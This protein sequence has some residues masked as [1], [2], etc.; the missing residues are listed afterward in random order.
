MQA[1]P[2]VEHQTK[3][4]TRSEE[5]LKFCILSFRRFYEFFLIDF[6]YLLYADKFVPDNNKMDEASEAELIE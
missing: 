1:K 5:F 4:K 3:A 2:Q 6:F